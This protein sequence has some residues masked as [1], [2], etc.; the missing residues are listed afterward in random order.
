M[1]KLQE[2]T[3]EQKQKMHKVR[4]YWIDKVWSGKTRISKKAAKELIQFCYKTAGIVEPKQYIWLSS[5]IACHLAKAYYEELLRHIGKEDS[6]GASVWASVGDS[7][8]VS[9]RDSVWASVV[10][11]VGASVRDSVWASVE[12]SVE[13]SVRDSVVASVVASV[14]DSLGDSLGASVWASVVASVGDSVG[15]SVRASVWDSVVASV[16][17]SVRDSVWDSV[18]DGVWDN[19]GASVVDSLV[20]SVRDSVGA[21]LVAS[22]GASV[23]EQGYRG[24]AHDYSWVAFYSYFVN[25]L[26]YIEND[27]FKQYSNLIDKANM[28]YWLPY[29]NVVFISDFPSEIYG[30]DVGGIKILHNEEDSPAIKFADDWELYFLK[31]INLD[32]SLYTKIINK[33]FTFEEA[34]NIENIEHRRLALEYLDPDKLLKGANAKL[35]HKGIEKQVDILRTDWEKVKM[36][37]NNYYSD[38]FFKHTKSEKVTIQ[39]ILYE[40]KLDDWENTYKALRYT[41]P[42][43]GRVYLS[44]IEGDATDADEAM[45]TRHHS[46][47]EDYIKL[48]KQA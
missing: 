47:K 14:G 15:D 27:N 8:G 5:P 29:E 28:F 39:N 35:I 18:W 46:T 23:W 22:L 12:A 38:S 20:A 32:K 1:N 41:D 7:L 10:A 19:V 30:T 3:K 40:V 2:L 37:G 11:S 16:G 25:E 4:D 33:D 45:A 17:A 48:T 43:T 24:S 13:A 21:S 26:K 6:V 34:M 42:S 9:V 31:G 44:W 36:T